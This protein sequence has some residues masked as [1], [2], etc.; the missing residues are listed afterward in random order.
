MKHI[1]L[2]IFKA[3]IFIIIIV[4]W[5]VINMLLNNK[6]ETIEP[7]NMFEV[8]YGF[9]LPDSAIIIKEEYEEDEGEDYYDAKISFKKKDYYYIKKKLSFYFKS[10]GYGKVNNYDYLPISFDDED[11]EWGIKEKVDEV[12]VAYHAIVSGKVVKTKHLYAV[13]TK[14][15][16]GE[17]FLYVAH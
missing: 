11:T 3:L 15:K 2:V 10:L 16:D 13:I 14:N 4:A 17:Y 12:K 8:K 9:R 7:Q 1:K 5:V 6:L